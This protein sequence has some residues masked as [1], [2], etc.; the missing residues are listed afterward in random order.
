MINP[1]K[2]GGVV[3][4][5]YFCNRQRELADLLRAIENGDKLFIYL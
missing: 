4:K 2:Y 3:D 5:E 1:F